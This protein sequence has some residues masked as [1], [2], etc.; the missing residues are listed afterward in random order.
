VADRLAA[1]PGVVSVSYSS[2]ALLSNSLW[3]SNVTIIGQPDSVYTDMLAAGPNF[4]Q[5]MKIPLLEGRSFTPADFAQ[6]EQANATGKRVPPSNQPT[7]TV[8]PAPV[9]VNREFVHEYL[10]DRNPIGVL[11]NPRGRDFAKGGGTGGTEAADFQ[12]VGV[13]GDTKYSDLRRTIH[14]EICVPLVTGRGSFEVR[15]AANPA[16]LLSLVRGAVKAVNADLDVSDFRTQSEQID[17]LL[18]QERLVAGMSSFFGLLALTLACIG[19]YGLLSYEIVRRTREIGIR[20]A[21]GAQ[22]ANLLRLIV[23]QGIVLAF[24]GVL[25]GSGVALGVTRYLGSLLYDVHADDPVTMIGVVALLILVALA[26]CYIPARRGMKIDP[27]VALG[28]E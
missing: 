9:L 28:Y 7:T 21:L 14:P 12:I 22:P 11:I 4:L 10:A 5:T 13:I 2:E 24:V 3:G 23:R 25:V 6:T 20:M 15:T 17:L 27:M 8:A 1:T 18:W 26:A 19:L 16:A